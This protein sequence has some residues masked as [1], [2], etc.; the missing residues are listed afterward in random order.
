M[1]DVATA[2]VTRRALIARGGIAFASV[3]I[4][5][6]AGNRAFA[7]AGRGLDAARRGVYGKLLDAASVA[8][9]TP[10]PAA[11]HD[12]FAGRFAALYR[13]GSQAYRAAVD[14][15]LDRIEHAGPGNRFSAAS[16]RAGAVL[17]RSPYRSRTFGSKAEADAWLDRETHNTRAA[18]ESV[19]LEQRTT[20]DGDPSPKL[21]AALREASDLSRIDASPE[22]RPTDTWVMALRLATDVQ[23]PDP[24]EFHHMSGPGIV[25][26]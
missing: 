7:A 14:A 13:D 15:A 26:G 8:T 20:A 9:R 4:A 22:T 19:P 12:R 24:D 1:N 3:S 21:M 5:G 11:E 2:G 25:L 17:L 23:A 18:E 16:A 6:L 10:L